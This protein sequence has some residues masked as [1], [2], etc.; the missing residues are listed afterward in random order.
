MNRCAAVFT[1][2]VVSVLAAC[3]SGSSVTPETAAVSPMNADLLTGQTIQ[4]TTNVNKNASKITWAVNGTPGGSSTVGTIDANGNYTAPAAQ[5]SSPATVSATSTSNSAIT[6]SAMVNVVATGAVT[7]TSNPQ[8]ATYTIAPPVAAGVTI[9]FGTDTT[10]ALSTN[11][12]TSAGNGTALASLVAGMLPNTLY[13][14]RA[15]LT[16]PDG[17]TLNDEDHTF[18]TTSLPASESFP[19]AVSTPNGMTPQPGVE[20]VDIV[21]SSSLPSVVAT[22]LN[23]NVIWSYRTTNLVQPIKPLP[24]GHFVLVIAPSSTAP[25]VPPGPTGIDVVREIDLAGNTIRELS[26]TDL[27]TKLAAAGFNYNALVMHHDVAVLPN[28]HWIIIVNTEKQVTGVPGHP[29]T[30]TLLGD[31]LV[32]LDTNLNPVWMW[33]EFNFLDTTRVPFQFPDWTHTNAVLYSPSDGN[34]IV[35]IRHQS[36]V[37][38][39]DYNNGAGAGDI[40]WKL[41]YQG[42]FTLAGGTAPTDWFSTQ[43]GPSFTTSNTSGQF[44][45]ALFDNGDNRAYPAGSPCVAPACTPYSTAQILSIDETAKT[46]TLDLN[47]KPGQYS[48]FGGNAEVLANGNFEFNLCML[49][50]NPNSSTQVSEITQDNPPQIVWSMTSSN[51]EAYRA[52]RLP[53]LYPGVQW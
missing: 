28:G 7:A 1:L 39:V 38:K 3:S 12:Q 4:F 32:D 8:V 18:T 50:P 51:I 37:V 22:D 17:N 14:M 5:L 2:I 27:N 53:S 52:F 16:M 35:S 48:T 29:G 9:Q 25:L 34:L 41:G 49:P 26:I 30:V 23:G 19:I 24:N 20:M 31:A 40:I 15:V 6:A 11:S 43:H 42:D 47:Y 21:A 36:W 10:Y 13:H 44:G 46:A 45:L 33:D